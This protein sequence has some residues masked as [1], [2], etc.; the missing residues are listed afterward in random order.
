[1]SRIGEVADGSIRACVTSPPYWGLRDYGHDDQLGLEATPAEYVANLVEVFKEV[2][3]V[4]AVDGTLW[5]NI[6]DSSS[7]GGNGAR[8]AVMWP[9]QSRNDHRVEHRNKRTGVS[10][11]NL[12]GIPWRVA[13]ALQ[14]DGW[15]L[16]SDIIWSKPNAMP[17]S[18]GDR[19]TKSHEYV[20]LLSKSRNYYYNAD[21]IREPAKPESDRRNARGRGM[22]KLR[23]IP[24]QNPQ[25]MHQP[26]ERLQPRFGGSKYGS[27][28]EHPTYGGGGVTSQRAFATNEMSG[29]SRPSLPGP[30]ILPSCRRLSPSRASWRAVQKAT[31]YSIHSPEMAQPDWSRCTI[32]GISWGLNSTLNSLKERVTGLSTVRRC[33][34]S[35]PSM[36]SFLI[37]SRLIKPRKVKSN[38]TDIENKIHPRGSGPIKGNRHHRGRSW[39][40]DH[41]RRVLRPLWGA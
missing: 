22:N 34:A 21:A 23:A 8:D 18:V 1:M 29:R 5:L 41:Q 33:C 27:S 19:P 12:I 36:N 7:H 35:D 14:D 3:R 6:G 26:K 37:F 30:H 40:P 32:R 38:A 2:R 25:G 31:R 24:G 13:F 4:L 15:F 39:C 16:R 10:A 11:K 17:E 9:K 20:F 28:N